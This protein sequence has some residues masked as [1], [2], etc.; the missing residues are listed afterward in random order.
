VSKSA[1]WIRAATLEYLK[2]LLGQLVTEESVIQSDNAITTAEV[3]PDT[4]IIDLA[5]D[6]P[7]W[8]RIRFKTT[9]ADP[10]AP[11]VVDTVYFAIRTSANHIKVA[12]TKANAQAG[13]AIDLTD[14]GSGTHALEE[15]EK[16]IDELAELPTNTEWKDSERVVVILP[17]GDELLFSGI[18]GGDIELS[19]SIFITCYGAKTAS[20]G[21]I[22]SL[23]T[24]LAEVRDK[25]TAGILAA[26]GFGSLDP[27]VQVEGC[28]ISDDPRFSMERD[29][30][31]ATLELRIKNHG[32]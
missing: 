15:I 13:T 14:A 30:S 9:A 20:E 7:D 28:S 2:T 31:S 5:I 27:P 18:P 6:V 21:I 1:N 3:H 11:L 4:D 25:I 29:L 32:S 26:N 12:T 16:K 22:L 24:V 10:P 8:A 23:E 19:A 17:G